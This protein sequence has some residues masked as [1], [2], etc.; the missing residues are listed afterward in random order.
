MFKLKSPQPQVSQALALL[1]PTGGI[2]DLD[3]L[4]KMGPEFMIDAMN[5][6]PD[7]GL[8]VVRPGYREYCTGLGGGAVKTIMSFNAQDGT[9][10]KFAATDAGIY[11]ISAPIQNP[12]LAT[13]ATFGEWEYTNFATSA[14]Q[15]LIA[16]NGVDPAKFYNGTSWQIFTEVATPV[17]P[18]E[19]KGVNPSTF[20]YVI[21]HKARLWFIQ[22]NTM[23]AW[24]LPVDSLGG[25]AKPFYVGGIFNRGGFLR[26]LARWSSDTGE[27]LDDRLIFFT[28]TGEIASY[29]GNDPSN[30]A[31]W[32][33]DS[34]FFVASPLSKRSV[35]PYGGDIMLLC[36][37]GLVPLSS[38]VTGQATEVL[39]SGA[40]SRRISRTLLR[41]SSIAAPPFPP[42]VRLHE[43]AA[44]AVINI[45]D[46][47]VAGGRFDGTN[48]PI[49]LVMNV[50]TG[51]WGKFNYPCRTV[52]SIDT[53]LYMGTD[54]G[55]VL[56]VTPD[57]FV[58]NRLFNGVGGDPIQAYGMGAYTYLENPTVNKH[59][60]LIRPVFQAEVVPSFVIRVLPDFRLDRLEQV[61]PPSLS[62]GNA[63]WDVSFWD[64][65]NWAGAENVYR[66]WRSANV[67]GYAFAW[68]MR[69][70]TSSALGLSDLEWVWENG[71]LV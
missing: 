60:K 27:G 7:N 40:L 2:N 4:A 9:F 58:D 69:I 32:S 61:P 42:E 45:F 19:I 12:V 26:M 16:V 21:A 63:R 68:Q 14:G 37:R 52:R 17:N 5:L 1:A 47:A 23:T 20:D 70:S 22:K 41:L 46:P 15:Y 64:Q 48:G 34:I 43:D 11:N 31:D 71:G 24:Y 10:H 28:S 36:R 59:A 44:W 51:A 53:V 30:S 39:Y 18:G 62:I 3:P 57:A 55:R 66:P 6:Y 50:L 29:A 25:E 54:D 35:A 56:A 49:Q 65:A 33:L 8:V 38:L 67:L 13:S